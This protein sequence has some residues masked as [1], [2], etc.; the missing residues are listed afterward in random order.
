MG[1]PVGG[2]RREASNT[3]ISE[4]CLSG[5]GVYE[6]IQS[7]LVPSPSGG[8]STWRFSKKLAMPSPT[9]EPASDSRMSPSAWFVASLADMAGFL[10]D[11]VF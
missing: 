1:R 2:H 9:S 10:V 4:S 7:K 5:L 8:K 3:S 6:L 11:L